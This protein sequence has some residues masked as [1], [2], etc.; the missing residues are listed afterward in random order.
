VLTVVREQLGQTLF[1]RVAGPDGPTTRARIHH[2]PGPPAAAKAVA[3]AVF[4]G[5]DRLFDRG[6]YSQNAVRPSQLQ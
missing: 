3:G 1:R 5:H 6:P 4:S 2:T